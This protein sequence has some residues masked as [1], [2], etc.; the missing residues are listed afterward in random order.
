MLVH[1]AP[2]KPCPEFVSVILF[3]AKA[4]RVGN[5]LVKERYVDVSARIWQM[6]R[7]VYAGGCVRGADG[8]RLG[9]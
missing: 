5:A 8:G 2:V 6:F 3:A 9:V 1:E 7:L 4:L